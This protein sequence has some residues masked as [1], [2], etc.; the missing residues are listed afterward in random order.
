MSL[1]IKDAEMDEQVAEIYDNGVIETEDSIVRE[2][3]EKIFGE[4]RTA[5]Y[6]D[7]VTETDESGGEVITRLA[8]DIEPGEDGYLVAIL[9]NLPYPYVVDEEATDPDQFTY[10]DWE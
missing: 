9:D 5:V 2:D 8:V 7:S 6:Y 4:D 3:L 10:P 1:T